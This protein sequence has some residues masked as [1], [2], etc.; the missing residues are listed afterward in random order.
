MSERIRR[1]LSTN[2]LLQRGQDRQTTISLPET[3]DRSRISRAAASSSPDQ[4][5]RGYLHHAELHL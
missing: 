2:R 1:D 5:G 4:V 3:M